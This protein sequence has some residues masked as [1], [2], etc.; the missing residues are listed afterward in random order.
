MIT[1]E[2]IATV[3]DHSVY[4][5]GGKKIG[6][7]KHVFLDDASDQPEWI[8]VKT[9]LF[10]T[11]ESFVPLR[12][13]VLVE[14]HLEVP[15]TKATVKDAPHVD[16]DAGEALSADEEHRLYQYYGIA[17]D[18]G[19]GRQQA[20][21]SD[22]DQQ[23]RAGTRNAADTRSDPSLPYDETT[24]SGIARSGKENPDTSAPQPGYDN[25]TTSGIARSGTEKLPAESARSD[26]SKDDEVERHAGAQ[27]A[28]TQRA[29]LRMYV[30]PEGR[31]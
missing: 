8:S 15:Y 20:G 27:S 12:E 1:Q 28:A 2:Q 11:N 26:R 3:L 9:G 18:E 23:A 13:A 17:W 6:D 10:G 7:T 31:R 21:R 4:D 16:L 5:A 25:T 30:S 22:Q 24:T 19:K 29:R 14:D